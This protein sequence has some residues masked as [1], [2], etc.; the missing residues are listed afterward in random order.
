MSRVYITTSL[1]SKKEVRLMERT[2][3]SGLRYAL[4][5]DGVLKANIDNIGD[6]YRLYNKYAAM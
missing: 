3:Y 2:T 6:A 4:F 5:V 1:I